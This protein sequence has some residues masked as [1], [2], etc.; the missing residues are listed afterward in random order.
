V[1]SFTYFLSADVAIVFV[2]LS[3][4]DNPPALEKETLDRSFI[5]LPQIQK[6]LIR[7]LM[8]RTSIP[9]IVVLVS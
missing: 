9:V 6:D 2:G 5:D 1:R 7:G 8:R 3:M 4:N